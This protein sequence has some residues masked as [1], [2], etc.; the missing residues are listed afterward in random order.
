MSD[1]PVNVFDYL[2]QD[3]A[4]IG[5]HMLITEVLFDDGVEARVVLSEDMD[6]EYAIRLLDAAREAIDRQLSD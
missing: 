2:T 5:S 6:R 4:I 3:G 1:E